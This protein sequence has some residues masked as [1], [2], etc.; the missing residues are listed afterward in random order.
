M[1]SDLNVH[2]QINLKALAAKLSGY[3]YKVPSDNP[4]RLAIIN[5]LQKH[6][7][8]YEE[9]DKSMFKDVAGT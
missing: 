3:K 7:G 2:S 6:R 9:S 5:F 4:T 1:R 8:M